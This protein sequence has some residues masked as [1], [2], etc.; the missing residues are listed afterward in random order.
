MSGSE[1]YTSVIVGGP[2][3]G[4]GGVTLTG[5]APLCS[6]QRRPPEVVN[7]SPL[8][9][10][11]WQ[12]LFAAGQGAGGGDHATAGH[13]GEDPLQQTEPLPRR[14]QHPQHTQLHGRKRWGRTGGWGQEQ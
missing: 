10:L 13:P 14:Q 11:N 3:V 5:G 12:H 1:P 9:S 7:K 6:A 8:E 4:R 2:K